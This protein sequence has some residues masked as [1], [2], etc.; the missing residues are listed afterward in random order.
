MQKIRISR[1]SL[2]KRERLYLRNRV[3]RLFSYGKSFR[4]YP[5]RVV[6]LLEPSSGENLSSSDVEAL[7]VGYELL[8]SVAKRR[9]KRAVD[10]NRLKR[11][12]REAFRRHPK[13]EELKGMLE[14]SKLHLSVAVIVATDTLFSY[15]SSSKAMWKLLERLNIEVEK[16]KKTWS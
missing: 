6:Y 16:V 11:L 1:E 15:E 7:P 8:I 12:T 9:F 3:Q 5:Y 14:G 2:P 13:R 4:A 10:R